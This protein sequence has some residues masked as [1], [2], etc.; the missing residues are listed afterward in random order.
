MP[1]PSLFATSVKLKLC[2]GDRL[3]NIA[4]FP[5]LLYLDIFVPSYSFYLIVKGDKYP[6]TGRGL[7]FYYQYFDLKYL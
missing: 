1:M 3:L 4:C 6:D 7:K 5:S 2:G